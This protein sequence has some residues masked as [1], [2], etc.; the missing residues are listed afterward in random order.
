MRKIVTAIVIQVPVGVAYEQ[1]ASYEAVASFV[2]PNRPIEAVVEQVS[3]TPWQ[4]WED[5]RNMLNKS[6]WA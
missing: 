6:F 1:V 3:S 5:G 2:Y 4:Q